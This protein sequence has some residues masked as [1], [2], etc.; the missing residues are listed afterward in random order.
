MRSAFVFLP[1]FNYF[2]SLHSF[3]SAISGSDTCKKLSKKSTGDQVG[4][5]QSCIKMVSLRSF[6]S[7]KSAVI[8]VV[9]GL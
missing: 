4:M 6:G 7:G 3:P 5:T 9:H 2:Q 1:A 8:V